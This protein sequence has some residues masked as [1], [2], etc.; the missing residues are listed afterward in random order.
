LCAAFDLQ[1]VDDNG[2]GGT[3]AV[4]YQGLPFPPGELVR[5]GYAWIHSLKCK[6]V[7]EERALRNDLLHTARLK[8]PPVGR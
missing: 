7:K 1:A 6:S 3:F 4:S 8:L 2:P 5:R